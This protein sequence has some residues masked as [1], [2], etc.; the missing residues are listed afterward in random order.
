M[1]QQQ[2]GGAEMIYRTTY[3]ETTDGEPCCIYCGTVL[4][5]PEMIAPPDDDEEWA[6]IATYHTSG[7]EW[8]VTRA[9]SRE[10]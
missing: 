6:R 1:R 4:H 10:A 8:V 3:G 5:D 2:I 9:H 7:C